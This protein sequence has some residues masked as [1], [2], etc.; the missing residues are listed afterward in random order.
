MGATPILDR[1][2]PAPSRK[3]RQ[4]LAMAL[5]AAIG[6]CIIQLTPVFDADSV[7][8]HPLEVG[9]TL[10]GA[11]YAA[12]LLHELG[13]LS[14]GLAAGFA[15]RQFAVGPLVLNLENG[16]LRVRFASARLLG[17]GQVAMVPESTDRLRSRFLQFIAGGPAVTVLL[18]VVPLALRGGML[19]NCVLIVNLLIAVSSLLPYTINGRPTDAKLLL[20][21]LRPGPAADRLATILFLLA[22][23]SRGIAPRDWPADSLHVLEGEGGNSAYCE[24]GRMF[25][26][27]CA[28]DGG[29]PERIA[30]ALERVLALSDRLNPDSRRA[31]FAEAAFV[32]GI[33]RRDA[34][35]ARA[36]LD[37][38]RRV[39]GTLPKEDWDSAALA[40]IACAEGDAAQALTQL[41]RAIAMLDRQP[42][43]SGSVAA[44]RG[45]LAALL[46]AQETAC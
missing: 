14:A 6:G 34:T 13:H 36:W 43:T 33:F 15:F 9:L 29:E 42:G 35:L 5:G 17:G 20:G 41:T 26:Y 30:E 7:L 31:Y 32:Q 39:K 18:F 45:R 21:L 25:V 2:Q 27:F 16:G 22:I 28:M 44:C 38:A 46:D 19:G 23:D 11:Y 10:L 40:G 12:V 3:K 4:W 24:I 1:N 8:E 37:D